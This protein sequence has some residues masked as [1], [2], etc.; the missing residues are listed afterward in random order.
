MNA[1]PELLLLMTTVPDTATA[2]RL[3]AALIEQ[4]LAACVQM[5]PAGQS[6]FFWQGTVTQAEER[7]LLIKTLAARREAVMAALAALH[8]Y[9]VPEIIGLLAD[10]VHPVY[11]K[12][13][14]E[15]VGTSD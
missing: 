6:I 5:L 4:K 14:E 1:T 10:C 15:T 8:P 11:L 3:S 7:L 9:E 2:E 13:V 12:W